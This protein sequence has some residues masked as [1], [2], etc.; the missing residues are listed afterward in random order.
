MRRFWNKYPDKE[1]PWI[2][3]VTLTEE[4]YDELTQDIH[5]TRVYLV[6]NDLPWIFRKVFVLDIFIR[7]HTFAQFATV[8]TRVVLS[9]HGC[10]EGWLDCAV[11]GRG[12]SQMH[13]ALDHEFGQT[14]FEDLVDQHSWKFGTHCCVCLTALK[15]K[16]LSL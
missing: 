2:L 4:K 14:S 13:R 10:C 8:F 7:S 1:M 12:K 9:V 3:S 15:N 5:S 16:A 6:K 11:V